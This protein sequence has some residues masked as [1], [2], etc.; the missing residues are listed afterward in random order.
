MIV[1]VVVLPVVVVVVLVVVVAVVVVVV[2]VAVVVV[3]VGVAGEAGSHG[4]SSS[5]PWCKQGLALA[6][7]CF[8]RLHGRSHAS[9]TCMVGNERIAC[10]SVSLLDER[11][12]LPV[13]FLLLVLA[14][15]STLVPRST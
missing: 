8:E 10:D 3:V 15:L 14:L 2:V 4:K 1:V 11:A 5:G 7:T 9:D 6:A 13:C 12:G